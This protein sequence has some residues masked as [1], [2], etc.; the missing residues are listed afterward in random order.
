M[1]LQL[2]QTRLCWGLVLRCCSLQAEGPNASAKNVSYIQ[3]TQS[4]PRRS[5]VDASCENQA[6]GRVRV[7]VT[8]VWS[9][10]S[11]RCLQGLW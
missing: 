2:Q 3:Q 9:W 4:A 10:L 5:D 7:Q 6:G 11:S 8:H 1:S